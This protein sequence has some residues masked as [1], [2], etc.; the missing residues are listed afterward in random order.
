ML[1]YFA[2]AVQTDTGV[3]LGSALMFF[4]IEPGQCCRI[5]GQVNVCAADFL[6]LTQA[7]GLCV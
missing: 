3:V 7:I 2:S 4:E 5:E 6:W 1:I